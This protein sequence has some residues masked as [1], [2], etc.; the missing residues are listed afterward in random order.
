MSLFRFF[1]KDPILIISPQEGYRRWAPTYQDEVNPIKK[2]SDFL[3]EKWFPVVTGKAVLDAGCGPGKYCRLAEDRGA[4]RVSG[5]DISPEMLAIA[6]TSC[7]KTEFQCIDLTT[8]ALLKEKYDL[9]ICALVL[10]HCKHLSQALRNLA[11]SV[12]PS[13]LLLITDFHPNQSLQKA[14][15][16]F[17]DRVTGQT[18]EIQHYTHLLGDYVSGLSALGFSLEAIEEPAWNGSPVVFGIKARKQ[19]PA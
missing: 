10:G 18:F 13:G 14:K 7:M 1:Q 8:D 19:L 17:R 12:T 3:I 9:V 6:R 15:R 2:N 4:A 11:S 16:T 5:A